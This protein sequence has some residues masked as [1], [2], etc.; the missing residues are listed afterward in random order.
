MT[1]SVRELHALAQWASAQGCQ[2]K[3]KA[4]R[5]FTSVESQKS[6]TLEAPEGSAK[7]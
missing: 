4:I 7:W 3:M 1:Q 2:M 6:V 5:R